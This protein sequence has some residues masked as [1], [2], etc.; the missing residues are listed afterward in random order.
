MIQITQ[1]RPKF[2]EILNYFLMLGTTGFGGP[3]ANIQYMRR[4]WLAKNWITDPDF[5]DA[6]AMIKLLPGPVGYQMVLYLANRHLNRKLALLCGIAYLLPSIFL[7]ISCFYLIEQLR[8]FAAIGKFVEG[9][10]IGSLFLL[11]WSVWK[12]SGSLLRT[13][14][15]WFSVL[16]TAFLHLRLGW[17]EPMCIAIV[18]FVNWLHH[19]S[20]KN[21]LRSITPLA[22]ATLGGLGLAVPLTDRLWT[23]AVLGFQ[24][25]IM[26]FGTGLAIIPILERH[27]VTDWHWLTSTQFLEALSIGQ[28][29]PGPVLVITTYL[30]LQIA[31]LAGAFVFTVATFSASSLNVLTWFPIVLGRFSKSSLMKIFNLTVC[32][33]VS[34]FILISLTTMG[35]SASPIGLAAAMALGFAWTFVP[36][37]PIGLF[38][39]TFG[40]VYLLFGF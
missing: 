16:V 7:V 18:F 24:S 10:A 3:I 22:L 35:R 15:F 25:G 26:T 38:L 9:M 33:V 5:Q 34:Y 37:L 30:G 6:F 20:K 12:L 1:Q 2:S 27:L 40:I 32:S 19:K 8:E 4:D 17:S 21:D 39:P 28:I 14:A 29:T 11:L 13:P 31:G 23:L 36:K